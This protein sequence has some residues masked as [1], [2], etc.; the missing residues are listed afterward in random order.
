VDTVPPEVRSRIMSRIGQRD[1]KPEVVTRRALHR[2]GLRFRLHASDLPGTPDIVLPSRRIAVFVHGCFWHQHSCRGERQRPGTRP[3]YWQA[4]FDRNAARHASA[5]LELTRLGWN[6][7]IV[8]ECETKSD[9]L[10]EEFARTI[11]ESPRA[12]RYRRHSCGA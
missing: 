8:W 11:A 12:G 10:L 6:A 3:E 4:K 1:T 7:R 5:V 2:S 9:A